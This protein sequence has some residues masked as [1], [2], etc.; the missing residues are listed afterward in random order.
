MP[1]RGAA[2]SAKLLPGAPTARRQGQEPVPPVSASARV[3]GGVGAN[4]A[5]R[6]APSQRRRVG[7]QG[8]RRCK[9]SPQ[10]S[11]KSSLAKPLV[12]HTVGRPF[13]GNPPFPRSGGYPAIREG[14]NRTRGNTKDHRHSSGAAEQMATVLLVEDARDLAEVIVRELEAAGYQTLHVVD[15]LAALEVHARE[16]PELVIL[17]WMLPRLDGLEVLRRLRQSAP[18]PV[19]MLTARSEETDRVVGL[20]VGADDYLTKP[21]SMR[22]LVARVRALLRRADLIRQTLYADRAT[23]GEVLCLGTLQLDP[24][25]HVATINGETLDL[26]PTE[27]A[28]LHLLL[29]SPGRAFS[30]AYLLDTVWQESYVGGD[31]SV[32]NAVLRLRKKLGTMGETIE[33]VWGVGYRLR[34]ER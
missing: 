14:Y 34:P 22:E 33:T 29:R 12:S 23:A 15:G 26:S 9:R 20:E 10:R 28:L 7:R 4:A 16:Q 24:Q 21:F 32:D 31:R 18:T 27:F 25:A 11:L 1:P 8:W 3:G 6:S 17:D 13:A 19:L 5:A 2:T 30:R